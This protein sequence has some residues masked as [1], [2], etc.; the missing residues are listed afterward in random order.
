M[1]RLSAADVLRVGSR[2]ALLRL[3]GLRKLAYREA[4]R[5]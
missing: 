3:S 5:R 4:V 1:P 2:L